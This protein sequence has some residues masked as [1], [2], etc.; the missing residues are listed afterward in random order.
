[1][2]LCCSSDSASDY[3]DADIDR[4]LASLRSL[5]NSLKAD[6]H[7]HAAPVLEEGGDMFNNLKSQI[8]GRLSTVR[9]L[10]ESTDESTQ[11]KSPTTPVDPQTS[12]RLQSAI[13]ENVRQ[14]NEEFRDLENCYKSEA[15]RRRRKYSPAEAAGRRQLVSQLADEIAAIK[16]MQK[17]QYMASYRDPSNQI[18]SMEDAELF[19]SAQGP[20]EWNDDFMQS[21]DVNASQR[22]AL[23]TIKQREA[24]FEST[25]KSIGAGVLDLHDLAVRQ[26]EEV[27]MQNMMLED[28]STR[29]EG[30]SGKMENINRKMKVT[31]RNVA[32]GGDKLCVDIVCVLL[33]LG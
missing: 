11:N 30:V 13:R 12:I 31:L 26:N 2:A 10:L 4:C 3:L 14:L 33:T 32:R 25:I 28:M 8:V 15:S 1:M 19:S 18:K 29:I 24:A 6:R 17:K 9:T 16:T 21:T 22:Q 7:R 20:N 5:Q 27:K 23:L